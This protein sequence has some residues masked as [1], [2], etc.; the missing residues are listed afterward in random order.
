MF[1]GDKIFMNDYYFYACEV[2]RGRGKTISTAT[3]HELTELAKLCDGENSTDL[4]LS[5][6][7]VLFVHLLNKMV[8]FTVLI[9]LVVTNLATV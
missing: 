8:N 7:Y 5:K 6:E 4:E 9:I 3:E 1:C 2:L